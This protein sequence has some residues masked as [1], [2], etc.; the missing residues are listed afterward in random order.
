MCLP[1]ETKVLVAKIV[2]LV[3]VGSG[4]A[5][6]IVIVSISSSEALPLLI[7]FVGFPDLVKVLQFSRF[8]YTDVG[9]QTRDRP[10]SVSASGETKAENLVTWG[11]VQHHKVVSL[12]N[13]SLDAC[14]NG[15]FQFLADPAGCRSDATV[16]PDNLLPDF[17]ILSCDTVEAAGKSCHVG[18]AALLA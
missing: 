13:V 1:L 14:T 5:I 18:R 9:N 2:R 12:D 17:A 10:C 7:R 11:P 8:T 3:F 15:P 6:H 4:N 16:I